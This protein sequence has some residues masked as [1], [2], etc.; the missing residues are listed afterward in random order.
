[1]MIKD[2]NQ[3]DREKALGVLKRYRYDHPWEMTKD[4]REAL[5]W[6]MDDVQ[7]ELDEDAW[8]DDDYDDDDDLIDEDPDDEGA[9]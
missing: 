8:L 4:A 2:D 1:M 7:E 5:Y 6:L 9:A 3:M